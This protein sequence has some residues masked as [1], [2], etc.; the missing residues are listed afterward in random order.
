METHINGIS[1]W[2]VA[3]LAAF[4]ALCTLLLFVGLRSILPSNDD[5]LAALLDQPADSDREGGTP[6]LQ[7]PR[8]KP[9]SSVES[10][11][12]AAPSPDNAEDPDVRTED[13][14]PTPD[15]PVPAADLADAPAAE[16]PTEEEVANAWP[17]FRGPGGLGVSAYTNLPTTWDGETGE[18]I[19]WKTA[20]PLAGNSS[21]IVWGK[22]VFLTGATEEERTVY[23]FDADTGEILWETNAPGEPEGT[24]EPPE[25]GETTGFAA[26]TPATDGRRVY[27][28]FANGDVVGVDFD[29]N[30]VWSRS[31]GVPKNVYGHA[32]SLAVHEDLVLVQM[33]QGGKDDDLSKLMALQA[34][35]G[36][37][38]WETIRKVPNSWTTPI[39]IQSGGKSQII[40]AADPWVISYSATDG[41]ELWRAECLQ[42][43]VGPSVTYADGFVFSA[44]EF[45]GATAIRVPEPGGTAE[46]EIVWEADIGA[47][48]CAS[49]L[50]AGD[51]VLLLASYGTLTCYNAKE[52]VDPLWE[53]DFDDSSFT[54]SPTLVGDRVYMFGEEGRAYILEPTADECKR[55]AEAQLG[56]GCVTSPACQDGRIYIRG[57]QHLFCIGE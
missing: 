29:G 41:K 7:R 32:A 52:G 38:V 55:I 31:F 9:K 4:V 26:C 23:C 18:G 47:P 6:L 2:A 57:E 30:V 3:G 13:A 22:R 12:D 46:A 20:V 27:A 25:V 19:L 21:P 56:E 50:V 45:P 49:P 53:E 5:Q 8:P 14:E 34:E 39:V 24:A 42:A 48:D 37:T 44:N 33:D 28:M 35:T 11:D 40:T 43:D 1:R 51:L 17:R 15:M 54:S 36:E 16:P 10:V